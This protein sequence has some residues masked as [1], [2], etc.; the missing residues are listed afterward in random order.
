MRTFRIVIL[1]APLLAS[2]ALVLPTSREGSAQEAEEA[3]LALVVDGSLRADRGDDPLLQLASHNLCGVTLGGYCPGRYRS[4]LRAG[5]PRA[6]CDAFVARC[7]ACNEAMLHCRQKVGHVPGFTCSKCR[8]ALDRCR[9][10]LSAPV[11]VMVEAQAG[12]S[13]ETEEISR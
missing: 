4:C 13:D 12:D 1:L 10:R 6:E 3:Q 7:N 11:R 8:R 5:R 2:A 9:A